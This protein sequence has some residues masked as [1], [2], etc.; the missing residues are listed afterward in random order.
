MSCL[1]SPRL[2]PV[3]CSVDRSHTTSARSHTVLR[4]LFMLNLSAFLPVPTDLS[5]LYPYISRPFL[6]I[7]ADLSSLYQQTF[8]PYISRPFLPVSADLSSLYQQTFPPYIS[9]PFLP[10]SVDLSSL[11]QQVHEGL[12]INNNYDSVIISLPLC[13]S[14]LLTN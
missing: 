5:S 10:I 8:P 14:W 12:F 1:V 11:Y 3:T 2:L 13:F 6:P 4:Q 7:S 9:R